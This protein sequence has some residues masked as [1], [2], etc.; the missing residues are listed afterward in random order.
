[1][2]ENEQINFEELSK[3]VDRQ[4]VAG[5][6]W[7][8]CLG[9]NGE[10]YALSFEEKLQVVDAVVQTAG[11][12]VK[13]CAGI[14]SI[15]TSESK[16]L[17]VRAADLGADAIS[18]VTPYFIS[19]SQYQLEKHYR[20]IAASVDCPVILYNIPART[21]N[22]IDPGLLRKLESQENIIALK[23]SSGNI[24]NVKSF[25]DIADDI[26]GDFSILVGS[27]S[28]ILQGLENGATGCVSGLA[29]IAPGLI[30]EIYRSFREGDIEKAEAAQSKILD[31]RSIL[32]LGNSN[33]IAKRATV[34]AG[35]PVGPARKPV[36]GVSADIDAKILDVLAR[37]I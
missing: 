1:M 22:S 3:Q 6:D 19:V 24:E 2:Y 10:F 20:E 9:T 25:I 21:G 5:V 23:D 26:P 4:V 8:F 16:R 34:L 31:I 14:G 32:S 33:T 30:V 7:I 15:T 18:V 35:Y 36:D 13:V 28:L 27:D 11:K 29:N 37:N 17:A 12:R